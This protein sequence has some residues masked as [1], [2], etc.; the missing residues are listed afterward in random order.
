MGYPVFFKEGRDCLEGFSEVFATF[1][2]S[3]VD[4][5]SAGL[6]LD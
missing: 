3:K 4:Q 5:S 6:V 2:S 1:V